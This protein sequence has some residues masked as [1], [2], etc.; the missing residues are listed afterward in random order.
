M[1]KYN[2]IIFSKDGFEFSLKLYL[3]VQNDVKYGFIE[4][5]KYYELMQINGFK[6]ILNSEYGSVQGI[7]EKEPHLLTPNDTTEMKENFYLL[8]RK[9]F[10]SKT[11]KVHIKVINYNN[12][13]IAEKD[14][15]LNISDNISNKKWNFNETYYQL[16]M[17]LIPKLIDFKYYFYHDTKMIRNI[18]TGELYQGDIREI[19]K[20]G[21]FC[22]KTPLGDLK[23]INEYKEIRKDI[24]KDDYLIAISL[25]EG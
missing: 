6:Q 4:K 1:Y 5:D 24:V 10:Y 9:I 12:E 25:L 20:L 22:R 15:E 19:Y 21:K 8:S 2:T 3:T 14:L 11:N 18:I 23:I 7:N 16:I 13:L 17:N